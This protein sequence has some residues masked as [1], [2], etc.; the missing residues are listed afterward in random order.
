MKKT[1]ILTGG[2]TAG[3]IMPNIALFDEL[4][5]SFE[6]IFYIGEKGGMEEK[7]IKEIGIDFFGIEAC[8]L[9]RQFCLSN[10]KIPITLLK[11]IKTCKKLIKKLSP[12]V[13]FSKGGY[14]S[15]PVCLA[16]KKLKIPYFIHESDFTMG[17]TNKISAKSA[18]KIFTSF[19]PT[20]E[21]IKN[22]I[23]TGAILRPELTS[24]IN[25]NLKAKLQVSENKP[26]VLVM[27]GS[28]GS[29]IIN[30]CLNKALPNLINHYNIIHIAGKKSK[31]EFH[32][33]DYKF[34]EFSNTVWELI[35]AC[36]IVVSRSGS[37]SIFEFL[38]LK[39][40]MLLIPLSKKV[41]RGDQ[42]LNAE[43]FQKCGYANILTEE[44]LNSENLISKINETYTNRFNIKKSMK[45]SSDQNA[46]KIICSYLTNAES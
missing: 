5:N 42:I 32:H 31:Q 22:S 39:K 40:P 29:V 20:S 43:Y 46:I 45:S 7:L 11:S 34:F 35:N 19:K 27:G 8:K 25:S 37:N 15:L 14:V 1:I 4:K 13:V 10:F 16:C 3:H 2:G 6:N 18:T 28:L 38:A 41:S 36:D 9:K 44:N 12:D 33:N 30:N 17:L 23:C 26:T 21:K 24:N